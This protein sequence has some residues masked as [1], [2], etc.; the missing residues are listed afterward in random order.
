MCG[1]ASRDKT[2]G[3]LYSMRTW[4]SQKGDV[5][6]FKHCE[7]FPTSTRMGGKYIARASEH[8]QLEIFFDYDMQSTPKDEG[9]NLAECIERLPSYI[10]REI[11]DLDY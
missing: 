1:S 11:N 10:V 2:L 8:I 4:I 6:V 7:C 5:G 3:V 9:R